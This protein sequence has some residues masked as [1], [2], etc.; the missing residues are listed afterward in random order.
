M[1][2]IHFLINVSLRDVSRLR[3]YAHD[4]DT[5]TEEL[6]LQRRHD[7]VALQ[8]EVDSCAE[9]LLRHRVSKY[10]SRSMPPVPLNMRQERSVPYYFIPPPFLYT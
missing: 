7:L 10:M 9:A 4:D 8:E 5:H 3:R 2:I 1:I 6:E